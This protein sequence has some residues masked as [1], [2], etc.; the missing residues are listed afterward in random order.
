MLDPALC[1][2]P[3]LHPLHVISVQPIDT[4][5]R[6]SPLLW[7]FPAPTVF[8][9]GVANVIQMLDPILCGGPI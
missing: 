3:T 5:A 9:F 4:N 7:T 1:G 2:G 6:S 8:H